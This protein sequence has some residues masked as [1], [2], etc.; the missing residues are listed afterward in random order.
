[1]VPAV[2]RASCFS[3]LTC[4]RLLLDNRL[5]FVLPVMVAMGFSSLSFQMFHRQDLP[6][7][8]SILQQFL[9][10]RIHLAGIICLRKLGEGR[11]GVIFESNP[12][13]ARAP[14]IWGPASFQKG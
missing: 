1:V 9:P 12:S 3:R 8:H 11:E 13:V 6:V 14:Y 10:I 2:L 7:D 5:G 4:V